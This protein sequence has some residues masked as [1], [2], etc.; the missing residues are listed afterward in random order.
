MN[1]RIKM[2]IENHV[3]NL[4]ALLNLVNVRSLL[5][6][7]RKS[8]KTLMFMFHTNGKAGHK[9]NITVMYI[10]SMYNFQ[11]KKIEKSSL[12]FFV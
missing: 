2:Y 12:S 1:V 7:T 8:R 3:L 5:E 4:L 9:W 11:K 6:D 10:R